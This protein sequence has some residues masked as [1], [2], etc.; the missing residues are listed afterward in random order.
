MPYPLDPELAAALAMMPE[1]DISDLAAARAAQ[2]VELSARAAA[3][4][5]SGTVVTDVREPGVA[6]RLYRP[7]RAD[8]PLPLVF[9][10]HGGGFVLGGPDVD[11]ETNLRLCRAL[12]AVIVSPDYR[13]APEHPFPAGLDDCYAALCWA[14]AHASGLGCDPARVAVAGDSAGACLATAVAL[15]ARDRSGPRIAFQ[16]LDSPAL[17][18]RLATPSARAFTDTPVWN[19]RNARLSWAAYLGEGVPG[20]PGVP[21]TAAPARADAAALAGLPPAHIT[22]MAFDP[23]RD[24]GIDYARALLTAGVA[25]EL[26]LFP[27][28]FHGASLVRHAAVARRMA[29]EELAVLRRALTC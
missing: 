3:A 22:V 29:A 24:E 1:V 14:A 16:Y 4:D 26:H 9:R 2:K 15:L 6:L 11:H 7:E 28:T 27:G 20:S 19:R 5:T 18:D 8:G 25:A 10:V 23:L 17:D 13:L 12:P 21:V